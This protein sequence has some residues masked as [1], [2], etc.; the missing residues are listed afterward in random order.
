MWQKQ[1]DSIFFKFIWN[2]KSEKVRRENAKLPKHLGGLNVPDVEKFWLSFK[3]SWLRRL[4]STKAFWPKIILEQISKVHKSPVTP[5]QLL[6]LGPA[7]LS[8]IGKKLTNKFWQQVLISAVNVTEGAIFCYPEKLSISSFWYNPYILRNN[9]VV[10]PANFPEIQNH[11]STLSDFF[12]PCSNE[13]MERHEFCAKYSLDIDEIKYID[14]RYIITLALQK[15]KF[16]RE[17][18]LPAVSPFKPILIDIALSANKGCSIYYKM[19][20]KK[21]IPFK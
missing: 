9:K 2:K 18:L 6:Q 17:K 14:L 4:L 8:Q 11:V 13:I 21:K 10:T 15:M 7:L 5:S 16:P 3:F 1:I 19:L 12:Q 20:M